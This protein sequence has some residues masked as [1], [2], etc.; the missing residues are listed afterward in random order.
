LASSP[1]TVRLRKLSTSSGDMAGV[2][3]G[4][5]GMRKTISDSSSA[6]RNFPW[7]MAHSHAAC[8]AIFLLVA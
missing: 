3:S 6:E 4:G 1:T 7:R 2:I 8:L 5:G